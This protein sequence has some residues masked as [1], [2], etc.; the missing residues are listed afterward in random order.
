MKSC[1]HCYAYYSQPQLIIIC[2]INLLK[3][4]EENVP[5]QKLLCAN[6]GQREDRVDPQEQSGVHGNQ[7][8]ALQARHPAGQSL[9]ARLP[10]PVGVRLEAKERTFRKKEGG[11]GGMKAV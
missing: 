10:Q 9:R 7:L 2:I 6:V 4:P 11:E 5:V 3:A 1:V 8:Q